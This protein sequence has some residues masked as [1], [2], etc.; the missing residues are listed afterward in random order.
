MFKKCN[1]EETKL[2]Y[3]KQLIDF[4]C[5][6]TSQLKLLL[7][8]L[9]I[10]MDRLEAAKQAYMHITDKEN[11]KLLLSVFK[12]PTVKNS[13]TDFLKEEEN[14][15]KQ[16]QLECKEP[17]N[18]K[19]FDELLSKVKNGAYETDKLKIAKTLLINSCV[20]SLQTKKIAE[21]FTHDREKLEL[22]QSAYYVLTDKEN[23]KELANEFQFAE[24]KTEFLNYITK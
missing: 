8:D 23:A 6:R 12:Y 15:L 24:T 9:P 10:E 4:N 16:K 19:Q 18:S 21:L 3:L 17:L 14:K 22:L 11:I 20:S 2:R 1:D 5:Y 7:E 13:Y